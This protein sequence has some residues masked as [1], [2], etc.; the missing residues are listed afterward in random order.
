VCTLWVGVPEVHGRVRLRLDLR[1]DA[2]PTDTD[3][4]YLFGVGEDMYGTGVIVVATPERHLQ[5]VT[6]PG[7][8]ACP[9]LPAPL[10]QGVWYTVEL[11]AAKS[12]TPR[13][14]RLVVRRRDGDVVA[15]ATCDGHSTGRGTLTHLTLGSPVG[16]GTTADVTFDDVHLT[17]APP[18]RT[19]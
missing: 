8:H 12:D 14:L 5:L 18:R 16:G 15:D 9:P 10:E 17:V 11:E 3:I 6:L 2:F 4:G 1:V 7:R 13:P 19:N